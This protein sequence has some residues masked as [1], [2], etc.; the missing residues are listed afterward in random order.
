MFQTKCNGFL[1][2]GCIGPRKVF[3]RYLNSDQKK[4]LSKIVE[5]N[6][7]GRNRDQIL[8]RI[9]VY[10]QK[11][12]TVDQWQAIVPEIAAY[13]KLNISCSPYSQL[14]PPKY[15]KPLLK[16]VRRAIEN[17]ADRKKI[18][19]LVEDY[20]DRVLFTQEFIKEYRKEPPF[21]ELGSMV[22][23]KTVLRPQQ[24]RPMPIVKISAAATNPP[25]PLFPIVEFW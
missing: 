22:P 12:L 9:Y 2:G 24:I 15:F 21:G 3:E 4:E 7:D 1:I 17:K 20:L 16:A 11:Q 25:K 5:N 23:G 8:I 6:F 13:Q 14:L 19:Y 18:K 10:L